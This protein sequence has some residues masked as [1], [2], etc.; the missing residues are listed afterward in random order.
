MKD[1]DIFKLKQKTFLSCSIHRITLI[2]NNFCYKC[3]E[4]IC[5]YKLK[6]IVSYCEICN[7]YL[8]SYEKDYCR[9]CF[10]CNCSR[11]SRFP[12]ICKW[13]NKDNIFNKYIFNKCVKLYPNIFLGYII[14]Q[15]INMIKFS[16]KYN[17][18][19]EKNIIDIIFNYL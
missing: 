14:S 2:E 17:N 13:C 10:M 5:K 1:K 15:D 16:Q 11:Y 9:G 6:T 4:N 19:F 3:N 18:F 12:G 8:P 7:R